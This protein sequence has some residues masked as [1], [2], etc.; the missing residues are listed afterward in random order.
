[1]TATKTASENIIASFTVKDLKEK[2]GLTS[3]NPI[4]K[5]NTNGKLFIT[6]LGKPKVNGEFVKDEDG[7]EVVKAFNVYLSKS[8]T[9]YSRVLDSGEIEYLEPTVASAM[10][11]A[12]RNALVP[13][14]CVVGQTIDK[15]WWSTKRFMHM[16][17]EEGSYFTIGKV[18]GKY[19]D[20]ESMY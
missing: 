9:H 8:L 1:M 4:V 13:P 7:N 14:V 16:R 18:G 6:L 17:G 10:E 3:L 2:Q 12:E 5:S 20:I 11:E 19:V 15:E